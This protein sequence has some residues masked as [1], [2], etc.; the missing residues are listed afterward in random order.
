MTDI[1]YLAA[2]IKE[3]TEQ[4]E[5]LEAKAATDYET[6]EAFDIY[7]SFVNAGFTKEQ[8]WELFITIFRAAALQ[9]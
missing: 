5:A 3:Q 1:E 6:K 9:S 4:L 2:R 7:M 8:A